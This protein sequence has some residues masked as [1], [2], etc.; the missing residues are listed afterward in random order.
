[1]YESRPE[2]IPPQTPPLGIP[3]GWIVSGQPSS[4]PRGLP[5]AG[6]L[7]CLQ[8][9]SGRSHSGPE[10]VTGSGQGTREGVTGSHRPSGW[11]A[12]GALSAGRSE[13][14][15][16]GTTL[17]LVCALS[18]GPSPQTSASCTPRRAALAP[19]ERRT[20]RSL[21]TGRTGRVWSRPLRP[22]DGAGHMSVGS[23]SIPGDDIPHHATRH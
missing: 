16:G 4:T 5:P 13:P 3:C 9:V 11:Q 10:P 18:A 2:K 22:A 7:A 17:S 23:D 1:M 20:V 15:G 6:R 12:P 8:S 21:R 14:R 19:S